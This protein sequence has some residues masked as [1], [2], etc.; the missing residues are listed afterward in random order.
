MPASA[1]LFLESNVVHVKGLARFAS[2][3]DGRFV[4]HSDRSLRQTQPGR[5]YLQRFLNTGWFLVI[6]YFLVLILGLLGLLCLLR[7]SSLSLHPSSLFFLWFNVAWMTFVTNA[8]EVGEN[9]R[10]RFVTDPIV[11]AFLAALAVDWLARRRPGTTG[12]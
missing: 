10:F 7:H 3:L 12:V 4:Y 5:Y 1:Y 11:S 6:A 8:L 9:N 2:I